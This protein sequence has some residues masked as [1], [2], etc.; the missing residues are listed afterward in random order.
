M[1]RYDKAGF[2][3][4][5]DPLKG[6]NLPGKRLLPPDLVIQDELHLISGPLGTMVGLYV[7]CRIAWHR[8]WRGN[9]RM[10]LLQ[11]H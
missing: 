3:G 1:E 2:Y 11:I 9:R 10:L 7:P 8:R 5:C 6:N 4:P